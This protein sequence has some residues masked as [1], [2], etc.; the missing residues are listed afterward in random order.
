MK[1]QKAIVVSLVLAVLLLSATDRALSKNQG[2]HVNQ[3][4]GGQGAD[5]RSNSA[6]TNSNAQWSADPTRGWVRA[7][8]RRELKRTNKSPTNN[9]D[10]GKVKV[11][12]NAKG[13]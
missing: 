1:S 6:N 12:G 13:N 5:H 3:H 8:E 2:N 11:K 10:K 9:G 7:E 4:R